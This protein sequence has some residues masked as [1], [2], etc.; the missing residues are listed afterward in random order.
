MQDHAG[1]HGQQQD[2]ACQR[3]FDDAG[4]FDSVHGVD[5]DVEGGP[6]TAQQAA[7]EDLIALFGFKDDA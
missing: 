6:T 7:G 2:C 1:G 3:A 4:G 5:G